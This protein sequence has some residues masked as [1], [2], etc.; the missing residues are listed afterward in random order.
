M[1]NFYN[2]RLF[3]RLI[4]LLIIFE[5]FSW[6]LRLYLFS[7]F[8][9]K[10]NGLGKISND[11]RIDG[12][13]V[14]NN[15]FDENTINLIN[16]NCLD[17]VNNL[18]N[19]INKE[20][21][22][23]NKSLNNMR[24]ERIA[25]SIK[26]KEINNHNKYLQLISQNRT[27]L[28]YARLIKF[29]FNNKPNLFFNVTHD[30]SLK[31]KFIPGSFNGQM[32]AGLPHIDSW[33]HNLKYILA[34]E[35]ID[36]YNGPFMCLKNTMHLKRLYPNYIDMF[37][38]HWGF[39]SGKKDSNLIKNKDLIFFENNKKKYIGK[40][41]KGDLAIIDT[42]TIHYASSLKKGQRHILWFYF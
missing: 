30:G 21:N 7:F 2:T 17:V 27:L 9:Q 20:I 33:K 40:L 25:G 26:I 34:L 37:L 32:I 23:S 22:I 42:R 11:L 29:R 5:N 28:I 41:K 3:K 8:L 19:E 35:D 15:F 12:V 18:P 1:N 14:I 24:V 39:T 6:N 10:K 13:S 16:K 31:N 38:S 36:E 4:H